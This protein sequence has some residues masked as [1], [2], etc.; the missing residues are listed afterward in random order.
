MANKDEVKIT[1]PPIDPQHVEIFRNDTTFTLKWGRPSQ[2]TWDTRPDRWTNTDATFEFF[3]PPGCAWHSTWVHSNDG[4]RYVMGDRIWVHDLGVATEATAEINRNSYHPVTLDRY[5]EYVAGYAIIQ[6]GV[7]EKRSGATY[8]F[9]NPL[10]PK[11]DTPTMDENTKVV[12]FKISKSFEEEKTISYIYNPKDPNDQGGMYSTHKECYDLAYAVEI[13]DNVNPRYAKPTLVEEEAY[14]KEDTVEVTVDPTDYDD[15]TLNLLPGQWVRITVYAYARG[16]RGN[17]GTV[18]EHYVF[19]HPDAPSITDITVTDPELSSGIVNV[20]VD[21]GSNENWKESGGAYL[22]EHVPVESVKLQRLKNTTAPTVTAAKEVSDGWEDVAGAVDNWNC[23]GFADFV[24]DALPDRGKFTYYRAVSTNGSFVRYGEPV[25]AT[26]LTRGPHPVM[27]DEVA[28]TSVV[29]GNDGESLTVY[30]AWNDDDSTATE[31]SW[32]DKEDAWKSTEQPSTYDV[33]WEDDPAEPPDGTDW[34]HTSYLVI[35]GLEESTKYY[36]KARRYSEAESERTYSTIHVTAPDSSFPAVP[37]TSPSNVVLSVPPYVKT[38]SDLDFTWTFD[39]DSTQKSWVLYRVKPDE[40]KVSVASGEDS[41]GVASLSSDIIETMIEDQG[42]QTLT[43]YVSLTTGGAWVD[44]DQVTVTVQQPPSITVSASVTIT[45]QPIQFNVKCDSQNVKLVCKLVA[46]GVMALTPGS[47]DPQLTGDILWSDVITPTWYETSAIAMSAQNSDE[48]YMTVVSLPLDLNLYD[49]CEYQLR[50]TATDLET[51]LSSDEHIFP[52]TVDYLHKATSTPDVEFTV[53]G[54]NRSVSLTP[55]KPENWQ[56]GDVF[57]LYRMTADRVYKIAEGVEFGATV[58]DRYAPYAKT[59]PL[60][61]RICTRTIDNDI[62]WIDYEYSMHV[63]T[64]RFDWNDNDYVEL[65]YDVEISDAY[66]KDFES[67]THI[68]GT[69]IGYWNSGVTHK[70]TLKTKLLRL[71]EPEQ[72]EQ[73][74]KLSMHTGPVYVRLPNGLAYT[75]NVAVSS[76]DDN[77]TQ[78]VKNVSISADEIELVDSFKPVLDDF[79]YED[80]FVPHD[81]SE[82]YSRKQLLLWTT[83]RT[84]FSKTY[85]LNEAAGSTVVVEMTVSSDGF[86]QKTYL[87]VTY[88]SETPRTVTVNQLSSSVQEYVDAQPEGTQF[89]LKALYN[90]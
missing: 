90:V 41:V 86:V 21:V 28:I 73:V 4:S 16:I 32:S 62:E 55:S 88:S 44:S 25:Q 72:I 35:R 59:L 56:A 19:A 38:G 20:K 65:P 71:M 22:L 52:M 67:R 5:L 70:G 60:R 42:S 50:I 2:A 8:Y 78:L 53:D 47:E 77:Y 57:D 31:V 1:Q 17:S 68:D 7:G 54:E 51:D 80:G 39:S 49:G 18:E 87:D 43:F 79:T 82:P 15:V 29:S 33:T 26:T 58:K 27:D 11:F 83:D 75:A 74:H 69:T 45:A 66:T 48:V 46:G 34:T 89:I 64:M 36:I 30:L 85:S 6:N 81:R 84:G 14:S 37:Y 9:E 61:Y 24:A 12:T 40:S 76:I 63:P 3:V 23:R 10:E 13:Q